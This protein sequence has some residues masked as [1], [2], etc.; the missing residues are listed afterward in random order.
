MK[1]H[2]M[3]GREAGETAR[4]EEARAKRACI[5]CR[6]RRR[7]VRFSTPSYEVA[8]LHPAVLSIE[9]EHESDQL[10]ISV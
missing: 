8:S 1:T 10:R 7:R 3:N 4:A 2:R 5:G 6:E 9:H